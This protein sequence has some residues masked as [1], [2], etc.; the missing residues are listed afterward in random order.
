METIILKT[1]AELN[2]FVN[3]ITNKVDAM[4]AEA[5]KIGDFELIKTENADL[6][7]ALEVNT[8][9]LAALKALQSHKYAGKSE[10]EKMYNIGKFLFSMRHN[11]NKVLNLSI[12]KVVHS[13]FRGL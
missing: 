7:A 12:F 3:E 8:V 9:E 4:N 11:N 5:V 6:K 2:A 10:D 1:D 13:L